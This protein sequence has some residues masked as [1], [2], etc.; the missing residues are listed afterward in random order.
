MGA[1]AA[2]LSSRFIRKRLRL[3]RCEECG[4]SLALAADDRVDHEVDELAAV[5]VCPTQGSLDRVA[6]PLGG[7]FPDNDANTDPVDWFADAESWGFPETL[8]GQMTA[9]TVPLAG[10]AE[11]ADR[12]RAG[13]W[14]SSLNSVL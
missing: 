3:R 11:M 13:N 9:Q 5:E 12:V 6:T 4:E 8:A 7:G 2:V 1:G 14:E 10:V